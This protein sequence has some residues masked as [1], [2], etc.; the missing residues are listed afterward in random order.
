MSVIFARITLVSQEFDSKNETW[1]VQCAVQVARR[2][3][4]IWQ[5]YAQ[6]KFAKRTISLVRKAGPRWP[7]LVL[8]SWDWLIETRSTEVIVNKRGRVHT[9]TRQDLCHSNSPFSLLL[10]VLLLFPIFD[11]CDRQ[12]TIESFFRRRTKCK[13]ACS[14]CMRTSGELLRIGSIHVDARK[15]T[16]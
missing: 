3:F 16:R 5:I 7:M 12:M 13:N 4:S 14:T 10:L 6:R 1:Y 9:G 8:M 15:H 2:V 11:T